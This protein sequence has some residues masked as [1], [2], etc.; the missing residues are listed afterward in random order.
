[1]DFWSYGCSKRRSQGGGFV[2]GFFDREV[3]LRRRHLSNFDFWLGMMTAGQFFLY[4]LIII[5]LK[6]SLASAANS[7][8]SEQQ[9]PST[10][11]CSRCTVSVSTSELLQTEDGSSTVNVGTTLGFPL[12][13]QQ[14]DSTFGRG[15]LDCV[16][17]S[18][19]FRISSV[20]N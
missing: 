7:P 3:D 1:V 17:S 2:V 13:A 20:G 6:E 19:N 8:D 14:P 16:A 10:I 4:L 5:I 9:P 11:G 15:Q 18:D 12:Q